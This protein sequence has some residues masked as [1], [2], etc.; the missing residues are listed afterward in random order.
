MAPETQLQRRITKASDV[1][2]FG[3]TLWELLTG[4]HAFKGAA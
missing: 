3:I 1:Y 2:S 4:G